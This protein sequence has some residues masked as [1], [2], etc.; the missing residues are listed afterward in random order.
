ML[1]FVSISGSLKTPMK[2]CPLACFG[3]KQM[4]FKQYN[5]VNKE[6]RNLDSWKNYLQT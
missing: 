4:K 5:K 6:Y 2:I 3:F 1:V